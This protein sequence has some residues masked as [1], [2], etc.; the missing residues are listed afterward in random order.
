MSLTARQLMYM[1]YAFGTQEYVAKDLGSGSGAFLK[2]DHRVEIE[3]N[4]LINIGDSF[5][6]INITEGAGVP[7]NFELPEG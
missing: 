4:H 2:I 5:L 3:D 6:L 7:A 1:R